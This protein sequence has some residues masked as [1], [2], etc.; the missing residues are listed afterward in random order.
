MGSKR[1]RFGPSYQEIQANTERVRD[2]GEHPQGRL[3]RGA[4]VFGKPVSADAQGVGNLLLSVFAAQLDQPLGKS[5]FK[6]R[7]VR[8]VSSF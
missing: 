1:S 4:F 6:S 7:G 3:G 5:L 2:P 8:P